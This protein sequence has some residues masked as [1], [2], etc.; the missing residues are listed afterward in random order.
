MNIKINKLPKSEVEID[1]ELNADIFESYY[2]KALKH[3]GEHV[4]IDGFRKGKAPEN[5]LISKIPEIKI[6]EEMAEMAL[7]EHYPK[8]LEE[9][10]IDA[11]G[12]PQISIIKLARKNPLAF[13]IKTAV[14]PEIKLPEYKKLAKKIM[15]E[16]NEGGKDLEVTDEDV[17]NTIMD[18]RKSRAPKKHMT[19]AHTHEDGTVHTPTEEE[20]NTEPELPE[21]N[22]EFVQALGPFENVEDF[23]IKLRENIKLEKANI[24]KEKTRLKIIEKI[25]DES[26][27][28]LPEILVDAEL[29]K[30]LY[31][32]ES[33][34]TAMGLKFEEYLKHLNKTTE[35]LKKEFRNDGEKKAKLGLVLNKIAEVEKI[36]ADEKQVALEVEQILAHYKDADPQRAMMHAETV[37]TNE[38]VFQMLEGQ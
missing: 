28:D 36:V 14:I 2:E 15:S 19:E 23:K 34:I 22:D 4:E 8:I 16:K 9:N 32:M 21:F 27:A 7:G 18:I 12:N 37:L 35:D 13:K 30:I 26:E 31:R 20:K 3:L 17:E 6:L 10:K 11:I 25:I 1:G 38:K 29:N 33:D 24:A 5:V